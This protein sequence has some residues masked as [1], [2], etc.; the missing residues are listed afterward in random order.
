MNS[1]N[2]P[3]PMVDPK[4]YGAAD[5]APFPGAFW[6]YSADA[7]PATDI[8]P[9]HVD[10]NIADRIVDFM[11]RFISF[12][13]P[14]QADALALW[15]LH[16]HAFDAAYA[17]P[18]IYV[19][20]AEK[21]SG[22]TR[23]IEVLSTLARHATVTSTTSSA[24]MYR[25]ISEDRPTMFVDE[26]DAIFTGVAN[27]DLRGVLNSG[28]KRNGTALRYDKGEV[29]TFS[30]F[31]PKLLAGIDNGQMPDTIADRC[32]PITLKRKRGDVEIERFMWRKVE[33]DAEVLADAIMAWVKL[34]MDP[35]LDAEPTLIDTISDR[36]FEI[37]EPL[38]A[39]A[40]RIP[41]W[42]QRGRDA[43]TTLLTKDDA[44]LSKSAQVLLFV[45][46]Y[47]EANDT[48]RISTAVILEAFDIDGKSGK[49]LGSMLKPYGIQ[50][51]TMHVGGKVAKGYA[52]TD[53][54]DAWE[55]YL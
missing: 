10:A 41:G 52:K 7:V 5:A 24:A 26:V 35:L 54:V 3:V 30:T 34:N 38:L 17:T 9:A 44:K 29:T 15:V 31:C 40:D 32:I 18:Y 6:H 27:E 47:M 4:Y 28:Y 50:S 11:S 45:K 19:H 36:A 37:A 1:T 49:V 12:T 39:I 23:V 14:A 53:F 51:K 16:T 33:R 48:D 13:N 43:L 25:L 42:H 46:T 2:T 21:Q 20:S 8:W 22:K 55:R